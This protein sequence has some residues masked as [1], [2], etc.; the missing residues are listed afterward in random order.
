MGALWFLAWNTPAF[1]YTG[2]PLL[3]DILGW[4]AR[5]HRVYFHTIPANEGDNFGGVYYFD[6]DVYKARSVQLAGAKA[7][8]TRTSRTTISS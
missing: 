8:P 6:V 7:R 4:D 5:T 2:G 3:V 1:A